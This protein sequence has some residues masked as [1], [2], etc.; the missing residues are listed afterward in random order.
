MRIVY[1]VP[2]PMSKTA[3]GSAELRRRQELLQRW[4]PEGVEVTVQNVLSGPASIES[5]YEEH[6]SVEQTARLVTR[7]EAEGAD[8]IILGCYGDPGLDA[9]CELT[10]RAVVVGPGAASAH[11]AAMLGHRFGI[12][13]VADGVVHP[14][15]R[16]VADAGLAGSLAGI[17][18][19]DVPVLELGTDREA[20]A[21]RA[22]DAGRRLIERDG[23]DVL[24]LGC[25]SMAFLELDAD[26]RAKL[27]VPVLNPVKA[28]L[29]IAHARA[30]FGWRHSKTA[31]PTPRKLAAGATLDDLVVG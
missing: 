16:L 5:A 24:V 27:G 19:V 31:Y 22:A 21:L 8:A 29:A 20:S 26:L 14:L 1:A 7:L 30:L 3:L 11:L 13:T 15:R 9:L 6:V 12:V 18:V 25:M 28:A 23:A 4:A 2:G 10:E 17:A